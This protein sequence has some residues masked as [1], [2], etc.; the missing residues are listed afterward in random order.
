MRVPSSK[1]AS[2]FTSV[3]MS[4]TPGSTSSADSTEAPAAAAPN[5]R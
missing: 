4:A 2:T 5:S 1:T 3:T